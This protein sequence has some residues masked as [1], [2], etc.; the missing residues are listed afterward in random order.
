M[1]NLRVNMKRKYI[2]LMGFVIIGIMA[3][4]LLSS[5]FNKGSYAENFWNKLGKGDVSSAACNNAIE[6]FNQNHIAFSHETMYSYQK[7]RCLGEYKYNFDENGLP[8]RSTTIKGHSDQIIDLVTNETLVE[9]TVSYGS[10]S[11]T[12][13]VNCNDKDNSWEASGKNIPPPYPIYMN[14]WLTL[15][16]IGTE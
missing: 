4:W 15:K 13:K 7:K 8:T 6:K 9:C 14:T 3:T 12:M 11:S 2:V 16:K 5:R 1:A 10:D